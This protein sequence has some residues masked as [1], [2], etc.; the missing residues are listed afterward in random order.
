MEEK[1]LF[2]SKHYNVKKFVNI[3]LIVSSLILVCLYLTACGL[4]DKAPQNYMEYLNSKNVV[5]IVGKDKNEILTM[6]ADVISDNEQKGNQYILTEKMVFNKQDVA[7]SFIF[8]N[9]IL[10]RVQYD[11]GNNSETALE[12]A[13]EMYSEF[14]EKLGSSDTYPS[15]PNRI[16][17]LTYEKYRTENQPYYQEYW[18]MENEIFK[19]IIPEKFKNTKRVDVGIIINR[20][21]KTSTEIYTD[22]TV[23]GTINN[24]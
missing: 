11:F 12:F 16:E 20:K 15:M 13:K 22:I 23:G 5:D 9:E 18:M 1:I 19:D 10:F 24:N 8:E 21:P 14:T 17:Q 4:E 7:I 2:Q 6:F 3:L